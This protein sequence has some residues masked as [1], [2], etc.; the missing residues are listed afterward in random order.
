[1]PDEVMEF[2]MKRGKEMMEM[3]SEAQKDSKK[4]SSNDE[5]GK[6]FEALI[7][8]YSDLVAN[9]KFKE[10]GL[11][12]KANSI[13]Y[14]FEML[15]VLRLSLADKEKLMAM[16]KRAEEKSGY[17][18]ELTKCGDFDCFI[19]A[20]DKGDLAVAIV[21]QEKQLAATVFTADKK[22]QMIDHLTGKSTPKET[23][24]E[25]SWDKFLKENNYKGF[26]DGFINLKNLFAQAKPLISA[27]MT[28]KVAEKE[29]EGC[30]AVIDQHLDN[31]PKI[32]IGTKKLEAKNMDYELLF[33]TSE[34]LSS[35]L[36]EISNK[37]NIAQR[38]D[39]A[40][41]DFGINIDFK[42]LR[43]ALTQYTDFLIK[44]GETHKCS[45]IETQKIRKSMG[46]VAMVMNMGLSQFNSLYASVSDVEL[47]DKMQPKKI[48]AMISIG[49]DDPASLI[50][51]LGMMNPA[52]MSLSIPADGS[53]VKVPEGLIPSRGNPLPP[54]YVNRSKTALNIMVGN[55]KPA[56]SDYKSD[57]PQ[58]SFSSMDGKRYIEKFSQVMKS[59]PN[60]PKDSVDIKM[61]E[62]MGSMSGKILSATSADKRGLVINYQL[63]Y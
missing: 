60:L 12:L 62:N 15:P 22:E 14:G 27:E 3:F 42:K 36:Q 61:L 53:T 46:G 54:L 38:A 55:D 59:M 48:D 11:S 18:V 45:A 57:T 43:E 33:K 51:M 19:S 26:G 37:T 2:H 52:I 21:L 10:T 4:T 58:I 30:L 35:V 49:S 17:K 1:M 6:F 44:T 8:D 25:G 7:Q 20:S 23:Y 41:F 31:I 50:A 63:Q 34:E 40:I 56:L 39:D 9:D 24:S 28:Q 16:V 13:L 29:I 47:D 5:I 32:L